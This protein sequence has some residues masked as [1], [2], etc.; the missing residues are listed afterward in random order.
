MPRDKRALTDSFE[1]DFARSTS[2]PVEPATAAGSGSENSKDLLL[3][4]VGPLSAATVPEAI[5]VD[6]FLF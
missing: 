3:L 1:F 6:D 2:V 4:D 5:W